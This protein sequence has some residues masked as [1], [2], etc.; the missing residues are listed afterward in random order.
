MR[1]L[2]FGAT[3]AAGGAVLRTALA[4]PLVD[5]LHAIARRS[6]KI[7]DPKLKVVEHPNFLDFA[8]ASLAFKN[9]DACLYCLGIS[10]TQVSGET[11]YRQIT[12]D[13]AVAAAKA[14]IVNSP[15][16]SFHF[17]SGRGTSLE[18][19]MMWAR[20]KA[21][22]ER[23]LIQ[24]C[25]A[26]CFRPAFIDAEL[27]DRAPALLQFLR[28]V[29]RVLK[30]FRSLYVSGEDLGKAMLKAVQLNVRGSILEN[31]EIRQMADSVAEKQN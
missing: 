22:T 3:G 31:P 26:T 7:Q 16:A 12:H 18:S 28:P 9:V 1:I 17:I 2:I 19:R 13:F 24:L 6:L 29:F 20:V 27:S 15:N 4:S 25:N 21:E 10:V 14:L 5:E 23:D 8:S 30:P 11:E